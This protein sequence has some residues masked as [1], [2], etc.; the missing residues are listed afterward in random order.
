MKQSY[1]FS[2][3]ASSYD[4]EIQ[5]LLTDSEGKS[6]L[7]ARLAEKRKEFKAILPMIEFAPEMVVPVF[8]DGLTFS[9]PKEMAAVVRCEPDDDDFP[10]WDG[11]APIITFASW[12]RPLLD[13]VLGE[14]A[15]EEFMV[16]VACLEFL[17]KF[18]TGSAAPAADDEEKEERQDDEEGDD[19]E[20]DLGE[21]GDDWLAD[22]GFDSARS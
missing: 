17:R 15:G 21:A 6:A 22:Q 8:Y 13:A 20:R 16:K 5:D 2:E 11:L 4:A 7:K 1:Y 19:D 9:N 14:R 3:L 10:S 12:A 18:D